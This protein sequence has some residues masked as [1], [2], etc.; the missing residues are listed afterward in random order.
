MELDDSDIRQ[1][2]TYSIAKAIEVGAHDPDVLSSIATTHMM[3][4]NLFEADPMKHP[5]QKQRDLA[6]AARRRIDIDELTREANL[7]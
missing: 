4:G 6:L 7:G 1:R 3:N 2:T 5:A